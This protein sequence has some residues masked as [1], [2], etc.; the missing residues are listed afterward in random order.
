LRQLQGSR[1][2]AVS[3]YWTSRRRLF[4]VRSTTTTAV[5][6]A[7]SQTV[8]PTVKIRAPRPTVTVKTVAKP[9]RIHRGF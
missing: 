5:T 6:D 1:Y 2:Q 3:D 8:A 4:G 7:P 9:T